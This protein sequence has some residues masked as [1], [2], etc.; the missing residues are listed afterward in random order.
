[1]R[2]NHQPANVLKTIA[3]CAIWCV[4][5]AGCVSARAR[6]PVDG[7]VRRLAVEELDKLTRHADRHVRA[8]AVQSVAD[9][10]GVSGRRLVMN[11]LAD[12]EPNVRFVA[13]MC[14]GDLRLPESGKALQAMLRDDDP[15]VRVAAVYGLHRLGDKRY[16]KYME[17]TVRNVDPRVRANTVLAMGRLGEPTALRILKDLRSDPDERVRLQVAKSMWLLKDEAGLTDLLSMLTASVG[18]R[19]F[20]AQALAEANASNPGFNV[21]Q[22][23]RSLFFSNFGGTGDEQALATD[24]RLAAA[25]ALGILGSDEGFGLAVQQ[26][27][28]SN[29]GHRAMSAAVF[30][31]IRRRDGTVRVAPLLNDAD[32]TVRIAAAAAILRIEK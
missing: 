4:A 22:H 31:A 2:L 29:A 12:K 17:T 16:T 3:L 19:M 18:D 5:T 9:T 27:K 24:V 6:P 15:S 32:A 10:I 14:A 28:S 1:M 7:N 26:M 25:R 21:R 11:G 13:A 8:G 30:G 20:A 23:I